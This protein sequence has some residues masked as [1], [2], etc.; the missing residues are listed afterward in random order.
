MSIPFSRHARRLAAPLGGV[1]LLALA[2]CDGDQQ[3]LQPG[4]SAA[5]KPADSV[6]REKAPGNRSDNLQAH[7]NRLRRETLNEPSSAYD[8]VHSNEVYTAAYRHAVYLNTL[9]SS[10]WN[11]K[12]TSGFDTDALNAD[13]TALEDLLDEPL[14]PGTATPDYPALVTG[15]TPYQR[16]EAIRNGRS[17][18]NSA[19]GDPR[20]VG[21]AYVFNGDIWRDDGTPSDFR[22]YNK[23]TLS[24][25][26]PTKYAFDA[27]DNVWYTRVGRMMLARPALRYFGYGNRSDSGE[28][29]EVRPPFPIFNN[30]FLGVMNMVWSAPLVAHAGHWPTNAND[31][32]TT[33]A[34][35]NGVHP[36]GL[37]TDIEGPNQY[38]GPPIHFTI[39]VDEPFLRDIGVVNLT[40]R[41]EDGVDPVSSPHSSV[42]WR[43]YRVF[44]NVSGLAVPLVTATGG[45]YRPVGPAAP[46]VVDASVVTVTPIQWDLPRNNQLYTIKLNDTVDLSTVVAGDTLSIKIAS[47]FAYSGVHT[48]PVSGVDNTA[49]TVS[50]WIPV[51]GFGQG[52][53]PN[54]QFPPTV[55]GSDTNNLRV[56]ITSATASTV[57]TVVD[58]TLRNGELVI[59]PVA[60]LQNDTRY[61]VTIRARTASYDSGIVTWTFRTDS[62]GTYP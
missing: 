57:S 25:A 61:T 53:F 43:Q 2:G 20:N 45:F 35:I 30:R 6:Y 33:A 51:G 3:P 32:L 39:P 52:A 27:I 13:D 59:V 34:N 42:T 1:L 14:L 28:I 23:D 4:E 36:Y 56:D 5:Y 62:T 22:G 47:G 44:S 18:L 24:N 37:D 49:H 54:A 40:F 31:A 60:P 41:R 7:L 17:V 46:V 55:Y 29:P 8:A 19:G 26:D 9:N 15:T 21:E 38:A 12:T 58:E 11:A 50:F 16:I 48:F 10:D